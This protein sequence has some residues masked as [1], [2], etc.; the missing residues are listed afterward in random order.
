MIDTTE[1]KETFQS[2][3]LLIVVVVAMIILGG[4]MFSVNKDRARPE[5]SGSQTSILSPV[6]LAMVTI[7]I[8]VPDGSLAFRDDQ[9]RVFFTYPKNWV[10]TDNELVFV[11]GDLVN[12]SIS[13]GSNFVVGVPQV[14][15]KDPSTIA[16]EIH[17]LQSDKT[18]SPVSYSTVTIG[19][20]KLEKAVSCDTVCHAYYYAYH[21]GNIYMF[22]FTSP[23]T[24]LKQQEVV[25]NDLLK[26]L[27]LF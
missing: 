25:V 13:S 22:N 4:L 18:G 23:K 2:A 20:N 3:L 19:E 26:T 6:P 11:Q 8:E 12:L 24:S 1:S 16:H 5:T 14:T 9:Y 15:D 17:G 10:E 21:N 27:I 7:E